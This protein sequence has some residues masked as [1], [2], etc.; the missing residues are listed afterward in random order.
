MG[1]TDDDPDGK[2]GEG[3]TRLFGT[4]T[5]ITW[6]GDR[7]PSTQR[8]WYPSEKGRPNHQTYSLLLS[9]G[10][11]V[12]SYRLSILLFVNQDPVSLIPKS[13]LTHLAMVKNIRLFSHLVPFTTKRPDLS[14]VYV[15]V[16]HNPTSPTHQTLGATDG[17]RTDVLD[18]PVRVGVKV[19]LW[20]VTDW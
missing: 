18:L 10:S 1:R 3:G 7:P 13:S 6:T 19:H 20:K 8:K 4:P 11:S 14:G 15:L 16:T 12:S 2:G 5:P 9:I 17:S